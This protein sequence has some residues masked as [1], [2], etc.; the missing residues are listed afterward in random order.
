M[1][2]L[3]QHQKFKG[4]VLI[5][6]LLRFLP[7]QSILDPFF[8]PLFCCSDTS[9]FGDALTEKLEWNRGRIKIDSKG[10]TS[11]SW[12]S[13]QVTVW[14]V[15]ML[16]MLCLTATGWQRASMLCL[17]RKS[18][19]GKVGGNQRLKVP[20]IIACFQEKAL[21]SIFLKQYF[22]WIFGK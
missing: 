10:R 1:R 11:E 13:Q 16:S 18:K 4:K 7:K 12:F 21:L 6:G 5:N 8:C 19:G 20:Q 14:M 3:Q 22:M 2:P 9:L 17:T 15:P